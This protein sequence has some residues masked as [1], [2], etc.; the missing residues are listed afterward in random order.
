MPLLLLCAVLFASCDKQPSPAVFD[1]QSEAALV[2]LDRDDGE[3]LKIAGEARDTLP[4]F[5]R[6]LTGAGALKDS[7]YI[8]YPF[9]SDAGSGVNTEQLWLTGISFKD[10]KY[11]GVLAG[12][13]VSLSGMR[14]GDTVI[15]DT[16]SVTDW[17]YISNGKIAG[18]RSVKYL[19]EKIPEDQRDDEQRKI[20]LMFE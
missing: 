15:F 17:M 20:L 12:T 3:I 4:V 8:K 2:Q 6:R 9:E 18:G 10:G 19:L 11:Y 1:R 5:F 16:G 14:K 7:F 13:P